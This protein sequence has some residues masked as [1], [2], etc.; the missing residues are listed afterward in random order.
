[1]YLEFI[2]D[3]KVVY[4]QVPDFHVVL[5][6]HVNP[7]P[8]T[9]KATEYSGLIE[10]ASIIASLKEVA[11]NVSDATARDAIHIGVRAA[12]QALQ[13]GAGKGVRIKE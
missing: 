3:G 10:D 6:T 5:H 8:P 13:K 12:I 4:Y 2:I 1:M 9:A 7:Q 11:K